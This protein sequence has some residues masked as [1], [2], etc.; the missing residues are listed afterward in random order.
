M[1]A[2]QGDRN[3]NV[4]KLEETRTELEKLQAESA[5]AEKEAQVVAAKLEVVEKVG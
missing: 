3:K 4:K 1:S 5:K 2:A